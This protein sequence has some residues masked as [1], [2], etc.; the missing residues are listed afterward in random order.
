MTRTM[1]KLRPQRP[2]P[3]PQ[4]DAPTTALRRADE[5]QTKAP[6]PK[7][8]EPTTAE[9]PA[10]RPAA[11]TA[12]EVRQLRL[13]VDGEQ[14][15][16]DLS[17]TAEPGTLT[18]VIGPSEAS[19]AGLVDVL[20]AAVQPSVGTVHFDGHDITDDHLRSHIGVVPRYDLLHPALTVEQALGY[21]AELRL[22][23]KTS[24]DHRRQKVHRA[25]TAM[26]LDLLRTVQVGN[27][28]AEQRKRASMAMELLTEPSALVL[29]EPTAGLEVAAHGEMRTTLRRFADEGRVVVVATTSPTD[30]DI[31]DQ[32]VLLTGIGTP[33][34]AGPPAQIGAELGTTDWAEIIAR[35]T[36]DPYGAHGAYLA[37][38]PQAPPVAEPTPVEPSARPARPSLWRQIRIAVRRQAWLLVGDQRYFTF[39]AILP[40]LFGALSLVVPG[41]SGLGPAD[42]YGS[43]PDEAVEILAVLTAG[44]VAMGTALSIRDL[45]GE[46]R[47]FRR[48]QANGLSASAFLAGKLIVDS[49]VGIVA[50]AIM[51]T[52]AVVGKGTPT[53]G[54]L[55]LGDGAFGAAVELF[56]VLAIATI[57]S[58]MVALALSSLSGYL[59]QILLTAVLIVLIST[60]FSGAMFP[61]AG[62]FGLEQVSW[63]VP[64]RW[65][66]AAA[67]STVDVPAVNPL[68]ASDDSWTHS[69]G[70]WLFDMAMLVGLGVVAT[71]WLRWRLR[72]PARRSG[73]DSKV[74]AARPESQS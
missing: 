44:A 11:K 53:Q 5:P 74:A 3:L 60:V 4:E 19:T 2:E 68:A 66:L 1:Q 32:V 22:A 18:T 57:V 6:E 55:L 56:V 28:T 59:E 36:T 31:C 49:L 20:G 46:R 21:A 7:A 25:L 43:S 12:L 39:L 38:H 15:L 47:I 35:V 42:P 10:P 14:V 24:A 65:A 64:S 23:P 61:I 69:T 45:F 30:I 17:F 13:G 26:K 52:A 9:A 71:G 73:D 67:A 40:V 37:R 58:A 54:G 41:N 27:L 63:L 48:E 16:A 51:A 34:F 33:A 62:R 8:P 50:A 72:R 29:D 70:R